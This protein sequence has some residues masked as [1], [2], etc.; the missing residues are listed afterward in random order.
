MSGIRQCSE[1]MSAETN[2]THLTEQV[3]TLGSA[4]RSFRSASPSECRVQCAT[5][6]G[7]GAV[8]VRL[9]GQP[10]GPANKT[11]REKEIM[12]TT[13]EASRKIRTALKA[14]FP[15]T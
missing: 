10:D 15:R 9:P 6:F 13:L 2:H 1:P 3:T 8:E 14:A 11:Q 12:T 4:E 7:A 5:T